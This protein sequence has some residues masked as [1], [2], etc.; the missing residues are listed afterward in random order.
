MSE[1]AVPSREYIKSNCPNCGREVIVTKR[2]KNH[3]CQKCYNATH[4]KK[5][6][7]RGGDEDEL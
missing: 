7:W 2:Q 4:K 3:Q 6:Y 1:R 5:A